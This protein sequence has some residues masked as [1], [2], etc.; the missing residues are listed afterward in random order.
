MTI[1][2][3]KDVRPLLIERIEREIPKKD[4]QFYLFSDRE[5]SSAPAT[6]LATGTGS[7][8]GQC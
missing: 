5:D 8:F 4:L 2:S 6:S 3:G 1:L 7:I